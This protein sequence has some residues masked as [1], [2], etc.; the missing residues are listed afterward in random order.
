MRTCLTLLLAGGLAVHAAERP[1]R[2]P[3]DPRGQVHLPIGIPNSVD[4]LK[5]FVEAEGSFSPGFGTYGVYCWVW[6]DAAQRL[7]APTMDDVPCAHGL[8]PGG[9]LIPWSKWRA[10]EVEVKTEVCQVEKP[11][12]R[13]K[14][15]VVA[16]RVILTNTGNRSRQVNLFIALRPLGPAGGPV[17][18]FE[19]EGTAARV[20]GRPAL[21]VGPR[22]LGPRGWASD[23]DD[24]ALAALRGGWPGHGPV[25]DRRSSVSG[26]C[27]GG[28]SFPMTLDPGSAR[29]VFCLCPVL[30]G[31]RAAGHRWDGVS[32]WAQFDLNP[33]NPAAGGEIQPDPGLDFYR[34]LDVNEL[35]A[36][37]AAHGSNLQQRVRLQLPDPRWAESYAAIVGHAALCLN[38]GAP[39][40]AVVNYNVFNRDGMYV[41]NIFQ[42]SGN[43]E[44]AEA[45]IDYFLGHPFNGR[46][47]PEAD[48]PGQILWVLGEHWKF[49]RNRAWLIR[50]YA[51]VR[52]LAAMIRYYRTTPGPHW[53]WDT[54]LDFGEALPASQR[55][56]LKPGACD[57]FNPNYTEAYDVAGLR[58]AAMLAQA[59]ARG[60]AGDRGGGAEEVGRALTTAA[61][62]DEAA[63][64]RLAGELLAAYERKFGSDLPKGYGSYAVLWPCR[65]Y[66][67]TE[68]RAFEQFRHL[69]AQRPTDWRYF[70]LAR[71][72][73]GLLAGNRAAAFE[74][75]NTHLD[76]PQM[77]GWYA[78]DEGGPSGVGGWHHVRTAWPIARHANGTPQ[79]TVAM[80]HGWAVA[81]FH[82]LLRDALLFEDGD[83]LVLLAGVPPGWFQHPA[84]MKG[85]NLP[86]HFG[87]CAF[88][89]AVTPA[90]ATLKLDSA[91]PAGCALRLPP[92][93]KV[94]ARREGSRLP[95]AAN[96]EITVPP[97]TRQVDLA[98]E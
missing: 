98:F 51:S 11:S 7:Y 87:P 74:T 8:A 39:D 1:A 55:K 64:G 48:N 53:V 5:T 68:G 19:F 27:S 79:S 36:E 88:D 58:A 42:K 80:P 45:A 22:D 43:P 67:F 17:N 71:A 77:R 35:F 95:R 26:E 62:E 2:H 41:A 44:L 84:G 40:V 14:A 15:Q 85:V 32:A 72:H 69:G 83:R 33:P 65:L 89:Y 34:S 23:Q 13:G 20:N 66:P 75:L 46:V 94:T 3:L 6:D 54:R 92:S 30:P 86:T 59:L 37:A 82:L 38:Q 91:A 21:L 9:L 81:E 93:L 96:G 28:F 29:S 16:A 78:F 97:R 47:Q 76:H 70:P 60:G 49:T 61:S 25:R 24:V 52:K 90:G 57:G 12:P 18:T 31:Q 10:G 63:W 4:A 56:E 50:I 73:Q